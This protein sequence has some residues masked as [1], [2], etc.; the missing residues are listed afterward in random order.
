MCICGVDRVLEL[1]DLINYGDHLYM[2]LK[3]RNDSVVSLRCL[4]L[5]SLL[6]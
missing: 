6:W 4:S 5:A 3:Y 2:Q 1:Q